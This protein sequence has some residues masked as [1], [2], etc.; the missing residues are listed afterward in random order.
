MI[1]F[2]LKYIIHCIE[3]NCT[4]YWDI[5]WYLLANEFSECK[6]D[7]DFAIE[8]LAYWE[9]EGTPQKILEYFFAD[10]FD[11]H[12][13]HRNEPRQV[14]NLED[15]VNHIKI[16]NGKLSESL[17]GLL[18]ILAAYAPTEFTLIEYHSLVLDETIYSTLMNRIR[19]KKLLTS[20]QALRK[21]VGSP[22][23]EDLRRLQALLIGDME[24]NNE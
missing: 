24:E 12:F 2:E 4:Y 1:P 5:F 16:R 13:P 8:I 22:K 9:N 20:I 19:C 11:M 10:K 23:T 15:W 18:V 3:K 21:R 7:V 6:P 14:D 17:K